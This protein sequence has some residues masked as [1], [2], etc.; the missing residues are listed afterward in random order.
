MFADDVR[1]AAPRIA[2]QPACPRKLSSCEQL[3]CTCTL[4]APTAFCLVRWAL[5]PAS[6]GRISV[7]LAGDALHPMTPNLGQGGCTALED[8]LVLGRSLQQAGAPALAAG[9]QDSLAGGSTGSSS[10]RQQQQQAVA[11]AVREAIGRYE[12]ERTQRC[13]PL[14]IRSHL[15]G[16][17]LQV[18]HPARHSLPVHGHVGTIMHCLLHGDCHNSRPRLHRPFPPPSAVGPA[19]AG[20]GP[21]PVCAARFFPRPLPGPCGLRLRAAAGQLNGAGKP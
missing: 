1:T 20:A 3:V 2:S 8:A 18:G 9:L 12:R 17:A 7:T 19:A 11:A 16:A 13:L 21:G 14:T 10:Q 4:S 15:M 5:P 6:S